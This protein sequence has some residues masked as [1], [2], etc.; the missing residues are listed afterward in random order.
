ND[1]RQKYGMQLTED[2]FK[3]Y[4]CLRDLCNIKVVTSYADANYI[5]LPSSL[6]IYTFQKEMPDEKP[7][8]LKQIKNGDDY[9]YLLKK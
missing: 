9:G 1:V 4:L 6:D 5:I 8:V 3:N 2:V 7:F